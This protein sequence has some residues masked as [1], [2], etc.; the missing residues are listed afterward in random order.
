MD[1]EY[2]GYQA[3]KLI[4]MDMLIAGEPVDAF[5]MI[6]LLYTSRCV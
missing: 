6:C 4:K 1:Y 5:S 3:A 2:A